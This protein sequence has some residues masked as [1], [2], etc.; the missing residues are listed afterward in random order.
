MD[1]SVI[2]GG[3][4]TFCKPHSETP[5]DGAFPTVFA[6]LVPRLLGLQLSTWGTRRR[7]PHASQWGCP[8]HTYIWEIC[9]ILHSNPL[10]FSLVVFAG[11]SHTPWESKHCHSKVSWP[12]L[13]QCR[14][15]CGLFCLTLWSRGTSSMWFMPFLRHTHMHKKLLDVSVKYLWD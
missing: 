14:V 11:F 4:H 7:S 12:L 2:L 8:G 13:R 9:S 15:Y 6:R 3:K 10:G 1:Y 5:V